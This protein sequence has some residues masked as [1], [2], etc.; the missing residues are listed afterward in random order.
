MGFSGA[1]FEEDRLAQ[2]ELYRADLRQQFNKSCQTYAVALVVLLGLSSFAFWAMFGIAFWTLMLLLEANAA[3]GRNVSVESCG[4]L[5][6]Q[7]R[8]AWVAAANGDP[9][10][11]KHLQNVQ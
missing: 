10:S 2:F 7:R 3:F 6:W 11:L 9:R 4:F 8:R 1:R 5:R